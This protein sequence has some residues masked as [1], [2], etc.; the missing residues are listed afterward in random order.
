MI[1]PISSRDGWDTHIGQVGNNCE[2]RIRIA[3]EVRCSS[4]HMHTTY[5]NVHISRN[6]LA[7]LVYLHRF[8]N[9]SSQCSRSAL[10]HPLWVELLSTSRGAVII[11]N[12]DSHDKDP[13]FLSL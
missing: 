3:K 13:L 11:H 6:S 5:N 2:K 9:F 8:F 7:Y 4:H 10:M 1:K 12:S